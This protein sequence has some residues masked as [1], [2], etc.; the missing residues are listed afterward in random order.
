[1][2]ITPL[3]A[4]RHAGITIGPRPDAAYGA[5]QNHAVLGASEIMLAAAD[6]PV[7]LMKDGNTGAFSIVSLFGFTP[8]RN[9]YV[10]N[11]SWVATWVPGAILRY[12]F[13]RDEAAPHG[14]AIDEDCGLLNAP[15]GEK[16]FEGDRPSGFL[17]GIADTIAAL[18]DD[19]AAAQSLARTLVSSGLV[20]PLHLVLT[21]AEGHENQIDGLYAIGLEALDALD[22]DAVLPLHRQ[23]A[24]RAAIVMAASL[25]QLE[26][27]R[28]LHDYASG[29]PLVRFAYAVAD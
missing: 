5:G 11:G 12:P 21:D 17:T 26:R 24:L 2:G 4:D 18:L 1:M 9:L 16:L 6:Y 13:Y 14:L 28:Q 7:L 27:V 10:M 15:E 22:D 19:I 25:G 8:G 20:K 3:A 23:G 29:Q